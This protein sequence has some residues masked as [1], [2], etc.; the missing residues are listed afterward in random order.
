MKEIIES[1]ENG[2]L[3]QA[4]EQIVKFGFTDFASTLEGWLYLEIIDQDM[5]NRAA[6]LGLYVAGKLVK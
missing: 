3:A 6:L 5:F 2:Q 1:I 4:R